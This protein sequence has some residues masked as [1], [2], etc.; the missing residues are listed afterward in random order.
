MAA[1]APP[2]AAATPGS[3]VASEEIAPTILEPAQ[4]VAS[5]SDTVTMAPR[6]CGTFA[7]IS[8]ALVTPSA[9]LSIFSGLNN[10]SA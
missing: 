3:S 2:D 8:T 4:M 5:T 1:T 9:N 7:S 10:L 6:Y